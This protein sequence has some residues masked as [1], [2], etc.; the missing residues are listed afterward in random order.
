MLLEEIAQLLA[1]G[2]LGVLGTTIQRG[3]FG[4]DAPEECLAIFTYPGEAPIRVK[5]RKAALSERP[6]FQVVVRAKSQASAYRLSQEV[7]EFLDGFRGYAGS[8]GVYYFSV[9]ALQS[10]FYLDTDDAGRA[11]IA[12]N[13]RADKELSPAA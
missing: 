5:D 8:S 12:C 9:R 2:G 3:Q 4:A 6:R 10:P 11:R 13:Y 1:N 7:F